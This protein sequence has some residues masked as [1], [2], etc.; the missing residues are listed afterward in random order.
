SLYSSVRLAKRSTEMKPSIFSSSGRSCAAS[1]RY[2]SFR[3]AAGMT[4]NITA[5]MS[6]SSLSAPAELGAHELRALDHRFHFPER[7]LA[8][9]VLHPAVG[10]DDDALGRDEGQGAADARGDL[11]RRLHRHVVQVDHAED[12]RFAGQGLEHR[13]VEIGLRSLDR[14]LTAVA[15]R[16]LAEERVAGGPRVDDGGV[17]E[18]D[19]HRG[20][21]GDAFE[22][23]VERR[24]AVA[25]RL[26]RP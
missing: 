26:L 17:S 19:V 20:G 6:S 9:Q 11:F 7:H 4:S 14:D 3:P 24:K 21:S 10:R 5:S 8:R 18:T 16:K 12:D 25:T 22:R 23:S 1:S 15:A 13:K 2:C